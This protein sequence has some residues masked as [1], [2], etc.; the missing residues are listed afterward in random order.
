M[1]LCHSLHL[2]NARVLAAKDTQ[3][4]SPAQYVHPSRSHLPV[5]LRLQCREPHED[6]VKHCSCPT[7]EICTCPQIHGVAIGN[8]A[9]SLHPLA[10][11]LRKSRGGSGSTASACGHS[12]PCRSTWTT[13][14]SSTAFLSKI[15]HR[16]AQHSCWLQLQ[17][18]ITPVCVCPTS[19]SLH[20]PCSAICTNPARSR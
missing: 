17:P 19:L 3:L 1:T 12:I 13:G 14:G 15:S 18:R 9:S 16:S 4:M 2:F 7:P 5:F 8:E 11:L 6:T 10:L 20:P